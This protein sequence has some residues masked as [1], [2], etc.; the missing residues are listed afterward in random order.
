MTSPIPCSPCW[1]TCPDSKPRRKALSTNLLNNYGENIMTKKTVK[2]PAKKAVTKAAPAAK[3]AP[4]TVKKTAPAAATPATATK[5]APA[6]V[7][8]K[9]IDMNKQSIKDAIDRK[10]TRL[11]SS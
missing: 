1:K 4:T 5:P 9:K 10:S 8:P 6:V 11:N 7:E 3:A 2:V